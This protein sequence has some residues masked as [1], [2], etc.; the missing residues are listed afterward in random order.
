MVCE[1][2]RVGSYHH[3]RYLETEHGYETTHNQGRIK[4]TLYGL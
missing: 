4:A 1:F 2:S 3:G